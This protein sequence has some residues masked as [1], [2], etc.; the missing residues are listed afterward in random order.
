VSHFQRVGH[1]TNYFNPQICGFAIC[2]SYLRTAHSARTNSIIDTYRVNI[3]V[4]AAEALNYQAQS[5]LFGKFQRPQYVYLLT[6]IENILQHQNGKA[7]KPM[8]EDPDHRK[9]GFQNTQ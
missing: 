1:L 4:H 7:H 5:F 8:S 9:N 6:V 2:G 3:L